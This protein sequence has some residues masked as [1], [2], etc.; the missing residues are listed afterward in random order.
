M[1]NWFT[2][3]GRQT[4][5]GTVDFKFK[6]ITAI[7]IRRITDLEMTCKMY[8]DDLLYRLEVPPGCHR[9]HQSLS[10]NMAIAPCN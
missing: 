5:K 7:D 6:S 9:F 2:V 10:N 3:A 8:A 4:N 1:K